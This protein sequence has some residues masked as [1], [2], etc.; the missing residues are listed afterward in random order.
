MDA[1][2][3]VSAVLM[4]SVPVVFTVLDMV[5]GVGVTFNASV[6][7]KQ[8]GNVLFGVIA[9]SARCKRGQK[10]VYTYEKSNRENN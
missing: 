4:M 7:P 5:R 3:S 9:A 2:C 10:R 1:G 6:F 8:S